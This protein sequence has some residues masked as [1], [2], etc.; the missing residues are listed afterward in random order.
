MKAEDEGGEEVGRGN[1]QTEEAKEEASS[2]IVIANF[3]VISIFLFFI[4][5]LDSITFLPRLSFPSSFLS[6]P[7]FLHHNPSPSDTH[8]LSHTTTQL[9]LPSH[10]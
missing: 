9:P 8:A 6:I 3:P 7:F 4:S 10:T 5:S 2:G 1:V